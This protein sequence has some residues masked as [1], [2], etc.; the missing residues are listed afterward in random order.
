MASRMEQRGREED[1]G[2]ELVLARHP[3]GDHVGDPF[4]GELGAG[5]ALAP[6]CES[7]V[8]GEDRWC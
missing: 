8:K 1:V 2:G 3:R 6:L 7:S 5:N 4:S